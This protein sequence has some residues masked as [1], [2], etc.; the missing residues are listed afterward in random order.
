MTEVHLTPPRVIR[1]VSRIPHGLKPSSSHLSVPPPYGVSKC[2]VQNVMSPVHQSPAAGFSPFTNSINPALNATRTSSFAAAL[3][4][5]AKQ[6]VDPIAEKL[7]PISPASTPASSQ[8]SIHSRHHASMSMY[9]NSHNNNPPGHGS[10]SPSITPSQSSQGKALDLGRYSHRNGSMV[11]AV[12]L[13][14][15]NS[16]LISSSND[17]RN[18]IPSGNKHMGSHNL[19]PSLRQDHCLSRGFQPYRNA[20]ERRS[21]PPHVYNP[22]PPPNSMSGYPYHPSILQ[23]SRMPPQSYRLDESIY[24]E[25]FGLLRPSTMP[26]PPTNMIPHPRAPLYPSN[27]YPPELISQSMRS[28]PSNSSYPTN[29][30]NLEE[31]NIKGKQYA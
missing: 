19:P 11:E 2:G 10:P 28:V 14:M 27:Q 9:I 8:Q 15:E 13:K 25:R 1:S 4:K 21:T 16:K 29:R 31:E 7:S 30:Y 18:D 23:S 6:A 12:S 3:R 26:Y 5:L 20:D 17:K 24:M 22:S